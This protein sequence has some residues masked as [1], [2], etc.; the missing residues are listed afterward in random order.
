M[1][2]QSITGLNQFPGLVNMA[3]SPMVFAVSASAYASSSF[4]YTCKLQIWTGSYEASGSG[5][6]YNIRKYPNASGYGLFDVSKF[7]NSALTVPALQATSSVVFFQP[8]FNFNF[9]NGISGSDFRTSVADRGLDGYNLFPKQ[10]N[11]TGLVGD[12]Y[13]L[14]TDGPTSQSIA[15]ND[16]GWLGVF[17]G[18]NSNVNV[19]YTG[20]YANGSTTTATRVLSGSQFHTTASIAWTPMGPVQPGFPLALTNGGSDLVSY[21]IRSTGAGFQNAL[22]INYSVNCVFKYTPVRIL[23]KNRYGQFDWINMWYKN[24]QDFSTEQRVYQPQLGSWNSSKLTYN[25]YQSTTQ[26]YT[27]D[28]TETLTVNTDFLPESY[29]EIFKQLLV[30]EEAYWMYDQPNSLY[31]PITIKTNNITFKTGVND[32][33]IQYTFTFDIGQP[34]KLII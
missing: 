24:V 15:I 8:T 4:Y 21:T 25:E 7:V 33:L 34:Y 14:M 3:Q 12:F 27:V 6:T 28:A 17:V 29:N 19:L 20:S 22:G 5:T 30:T 32:K 9:E 1:P 2:I 26:R 31:K 18:V 13:P 23:W 11:S 10:I 16:K